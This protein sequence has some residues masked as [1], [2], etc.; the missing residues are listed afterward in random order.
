MSASAYRAQCNLQAS[1]MFELKYS[2]QL[3]KCLFHADT[4]CIVV[5]MLVQWQPIRVALHQ[6]IYER[7][8]VAVL[9]NH[10]PC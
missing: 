1:V 8:E 2:K 9:H 3:P 7:A 10:F 6:Y 4:Y 5:Q